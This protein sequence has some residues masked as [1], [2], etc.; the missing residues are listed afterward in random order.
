M[1]QDFGTNC[2]SRVRKVPEFIL[3]IFKDELKTASAAP[4]AQDIVK[5]SWCN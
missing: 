3:C 1:F 5:R 2:V 4:I